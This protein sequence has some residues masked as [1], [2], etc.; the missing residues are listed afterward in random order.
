MSALQPISAPDWPLTE[1]AGACA[2]CRHERCQPVCMSY[3]TLEHPSQQELCTAGYTP[4]TAT[5]PASLL[6]THTCLTSHAAACCHA[7]SAAGRRPLRACPSPCSRWL[8]ATAA[9]AAAGEAAALAVVVAS[10]GGPATQMRRTQTQMTRARRPGTRATSEWAFGAAFWCRLGSVQIHSSLCRRWLAPRV[11]RATEAT[12]SCRYI[13]MP[14]V[15]RVLI[16]TFP[17]CVSLQLVG[18]QPA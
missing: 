16:I 14:C 6:S 7:A 9:A 3:I 5:M 10:A 17:V 8:A 2:K 12:E 1:Q 4:N 11:T 15:W 18:H 13:C